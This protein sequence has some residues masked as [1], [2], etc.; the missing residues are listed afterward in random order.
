MADNDFGWTGVNCGE[1]SRICE[2]S[3]RVWRLLLGRMWGE[4]VTV[5]VVVDVVGRMRL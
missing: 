1:A 2:D 4:F 3:R 5:T